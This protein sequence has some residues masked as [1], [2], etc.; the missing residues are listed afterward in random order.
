MCW[1]S[2]FTSLNQAKAL[3]GASYV[4][5]NL[6]MDLRFKLYT[7]MAVNSI[8][9]SAP[10]CMMDAL[11]GVG[12]STMHHYFWDYPLLILCPLEHDRTLRGYR[13]LMANIMRK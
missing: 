12:I 3:V 7:R 8:V 11:D 4:I 10:Q 9:N 6:H 1:C 13:N 5:T 2:N